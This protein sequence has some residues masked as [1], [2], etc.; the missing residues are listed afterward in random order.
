MGVVLMP[1][2]F[3]YT[4]RFPWFFSLDDDLG[5][6]FVSKMADFDRNGMRRVGRFGIGVFSVFFRQPAEIFTVPKSL[7][8]KTDVAHGR[9]D[10]VGD[11]RAP[12][13][14][15]R[16]F[17]AARPNRFSILRFRVNFSYL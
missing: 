14:E 12:A 7:V 16:R 2:S 6:E 17:C 1:R 5:L 10:A 4:G 13:V 3:F 15:P 9:P 8:D 11:R